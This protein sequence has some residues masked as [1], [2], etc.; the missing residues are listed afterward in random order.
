[1]VCCTWV[2]HAARLRIGCICRRSRSRAACIAAGSTDA[3]GRMPP[4][5]STAI[6]WESLWSL[7]ALP[8]WIAFIA[9]V[10]EDHR[11][12]FWRP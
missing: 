1:V 8:P 9:R 7:L 10:A 2:S 6:F 12:A 4:R 5:R 3:W 11:E